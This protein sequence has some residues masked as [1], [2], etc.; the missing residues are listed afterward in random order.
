MTLH[1]GAWLGFA[2][3]TVGLGLPACG[4]TANDA[5]SDTSSGGASTPVDGNADPGN[6]GGSP[7]ADASGDVSLDEPMGF[8]LYL[9]KTNALVKPDGYVDATYENG[10]CVTLAPVAPP[11]DYSG[12]APVTVRVDFAEPGQAESLGA[13]GV[14]YTTVNGYWLGI[15]DLTVERASGAVH[16]N[17]T[18]VGDMDFPFDGG[19]AACQVDD[20]TQLSDPVSALVFILDLSSVGSSSGAKFCILN[21]R[22]VDDSYLTRKPG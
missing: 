6:E 18:Y 3:L 1:G 11:A 15:V 7:D 8:P 21:L 22:F 5:A 12:H 14:L 10:D 19:D 2:L 9:H 16:C 20:G 4:Q 17:V 13:T